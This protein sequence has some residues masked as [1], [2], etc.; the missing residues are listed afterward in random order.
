MRVSGFTFIRN[1]VKYDY[2]VVEA[3]NSILP[4]VDD[5][6]VAVGNS[7]DETLELIK[8]INSDKIKIIETLWDDSQREGGRVLALETDKAFQAISAASDW[9]FY[10][11]ADE[12]IHEQDIPVIKAAMHQYLDD[13]R[14]DGLLFNFLSFYGSFSYVADNYDWVRREVRVIK[15]NKQIYSY[16]D[17]LGFRKNDNEKLK[18]K[19]VKATIYHYGWVRPPQ[20]MQ[21][22]QANFQRLWHNDQWIEKYVVDTSDYDYSQIE[23]LSEYKGSHPAVMQIRIE[24]INWEFRFDLSK[25]KTKFKY[26]VKRLIERLTGYVVGEFRNYKI[27]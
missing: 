7:D 14:V 24:S 3:I 6:V 4:L 21:Q 20:I 15:N 16:G 19:S 25:R 5:F 9:C 1:G 10:L 17:A 26:K 23:W 18:V 12:V 13:E 2:P 11:Q 8:S 22:K 27:I